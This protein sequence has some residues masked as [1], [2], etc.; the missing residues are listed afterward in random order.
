MSASN[1]METGLLN[2]IFD[3]I[4]LANIGNAGGLQPSTADGSV[5]IALFT[6][7]PTDADTG[8]E[9]T[10]TGYARIAVGRTSGFTVSGNLA[11]NA[12]AIVFDICTGGT[13]TITHF[14][15]YTAVTSGDLLFSGALGSSLAVSNNITPEIAINDLDITAD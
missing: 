12:A 10:Y 15:I 2:L 8:S 4:A 13:N 7:D 3:N 14:G 6:T 1:L 11:T 9:A 5:F